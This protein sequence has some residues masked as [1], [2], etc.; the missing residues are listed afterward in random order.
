MECPVC[1]RANA[2]IQKITRQYSRKN[3]SLTITNVLVKH[4]PDCKEDYIEASILQK[5]DDIKKY[6]DPSINLTSNGIIEINFETAIFLD[7]ETE[8][9]VQPKHT[10]NIENLKLGVSDRV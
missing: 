8:K 4:C 9:Q 5:L 3:C 2:E 7:K 1:D 10:P 6:F